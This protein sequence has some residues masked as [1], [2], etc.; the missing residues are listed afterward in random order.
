MNGRE[1]P[2]MPEWVVVLVVGAIGGFINS[3][4]F[5]GGWVSSKRIRGTRGR[6]VYDFGTI[7]NAVIGAAA[8]W[9][10]WALYTPGA[11]FASDA[12]RPQV[13]GGAALAGFTGGSTLR[14][15]SERQLAALG[16]EGTRETIRRLSRRRN[17]GDGREPE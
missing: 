16:R 11:D 1:W 7:G 2:I 4:V 3:L 5:D 12:L 10:T 8:A 9:V 15:L 17:R 13:L 6:A 14:V